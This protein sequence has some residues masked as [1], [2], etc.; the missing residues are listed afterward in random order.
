MKS[1]IKKN[2][3]S[4]KSSLDYLQVGGKKQVPGQRP[5]YVMLGLNVMMREVHSPLEKEKERF[6]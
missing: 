5:L 4:P 3:V 2:E 1:L 6:I